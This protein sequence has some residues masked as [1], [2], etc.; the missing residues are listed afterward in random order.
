MKVASPILLDQS[1]HKNIYLC[2]P[3]NGCSDEECND[4]RNLVRSLLEGNLEFDT[5]DPMR[6]DYRGREKECTDEIVEGDKEDIDNS[7]LLLVGYSK[8]SVGTSMEILYAWERNKPII[9]VTSSSTVISPWLRYHVTAIVSTF[10]E[11]VNLITGRKV[12]NDS[13]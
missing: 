4:W 8:P 9:L 10:V 11:A 13:N 7:Y 12:L 6:R 3:I 1:E 2:G 5:L